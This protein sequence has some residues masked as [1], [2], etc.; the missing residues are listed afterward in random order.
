VD[1]INQ[2]IP[3][4]ERRLRIPDIKFNRRIGQY[5]HQC[6]TFDG[7][8]MAQERYAEYLATVMPQPPDYAR[9]NDIL[10]EPDWITA[11]KADMPDTA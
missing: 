9:L 1:R 10:K 2:L 3:E 8:P 11:K 7:E 4:R 6:Y 5:A